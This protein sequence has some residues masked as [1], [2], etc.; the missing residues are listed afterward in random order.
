M[1]DRRRTWRWHRS[2]LRRRCDVVEAVVLLVLS[3]LLVAGPVLVGTLAFASTWQ[4]ALRQE[5]TRHSTPAVVVDDARSAAPNP[6]VR[7]SNG[8][9][10]ATVRWQEPDGTERTQTVPLERGGE[11][12]D[13]VTVWLDSSGA[14][15]EAPPGPVARAV[16]SSASGLLAAGGVGAALLLAR[17]LAR[18]RF[19]RGHDRSWGREWMEVEPRWARRYH[20]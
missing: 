10:T 3:V 12:G 17:H 7:P 16:Q 15:T 9:T 8:E 13:E 6:A 20:S 5:Q 2:P 11:P 14:P 4:S 18:E 19:E 1:A